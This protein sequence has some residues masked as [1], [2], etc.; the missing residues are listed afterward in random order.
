MARETRW[1][2]APPAA[3]V[4]ELATISFF[5]IAATSVPLERL[6]ENLQAVRQLCDERGVVGT[7]ILAADGLNGTLAGDCSAV[8][9]VVRCIAE[10]PLWGDAFSSPPRAGCASE[11]A[12]GTELVTNE[13]LCRGRPPPYKRLKV[14]VKAELIALDLPSTVALD[15]QCRGTEIEPADWDSVTQEE[16]VLL[17]DV[18]NDYETSLGTFRGAVPTP[19]NTFREFPRWANEHLRR[20]ETTEEAKP[21]AQSELPRRVAMFCTGGVRCEKASAYLIQHCGYD[22]SDVLQLRGGIQSYLTHMASG[23]QL[24][25]RSSQSQEAPLTDE[26]SSISPDSAGIWDG[27]CYVFDERTALNARGTSIGK[28]EAL[29]IASGLKVGSNRGDGERLAT[30]HQ[31]PR[32]ADDDVESR[33]NADDAVPSAIDHRGLDS[34]GSN[35]EGNDRGRPRQSAAEKAQKSLLRRAQQ[36]EELLGR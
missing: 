13:E 16:G 32:R 27:L 35:S 30:T 12:G 6:R 19:T 25:E 15:L 1:A 20:D 31:H 7:V 11:V 17:L 14:K 24:L 5:R 26:R 22:P 2:A 23:S 18:R 9:Q 8:R 36:T 3:P 34:G 10:H 21:Q 33:A 28:E 29:Q 4:D